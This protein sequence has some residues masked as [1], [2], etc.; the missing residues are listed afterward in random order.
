MINSHSF[1]TFLGIDVSKDK[2]D[3]Y[4]SETQKSVT[5]PNTL[6]GIRGYLKTL[7]FSPSRLVVIDL[8]G[9]YEHLAVNLFYQAKFCIH[10]A[11]G[12]RVKYFLKSFGQQAK[13][14]SLDAKGLALY[15]EK[16]GDR[17]RLY[18][19]VDG[20]LL[21]LSG[22]LFDLKA[23]AQVEKNRAQAPKVPKSLVHQIQEHIAYLEKNIANLEKALEAIILED[24]VLRR[25]YEVLMSIK[26]IGKTTAITLLA[27]LPELGEVNR[28]KIAALA[29]VA[30]YAKDSGTL[31]GHRFVRYGRPVA[32]SAL[33]MAALV[34]IR[35]DQ[36]IQNFYN[37]LINNA[38][39]K[40]V[41]ITASMRK[42]LII[43]NA[44]IKD[45]SSL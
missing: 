22:R 2:L 31:S 30:P 1:N 34:S 26:G 25:K 45:A 44:K 9:G 36:R 27:V 20:R 14:D 3:I 7:D 8:T 19:P 33:F 16:M 4:D 37:S 13:T 39:P 11:E 29:G 15:G 18:Q 21:E 5:V 10:R 17:L 42:I 28:R 24:E 6:K 23:M 40:M 38:K 43:A 41:S 35:Y 32:K 12:R